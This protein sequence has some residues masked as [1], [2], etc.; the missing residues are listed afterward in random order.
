MADRKAVSRR[1]WRLHWPLLLAATIGIS[2]G[3]IPTMTLGL[4]M[5]PLQN[6]FGWN[7]TTISLGM[8]VFAMLTAPLTPFA[9][10][11]VDRY[12]ARTIAIPGLFLSGLCFA[13]FGLMN[14]MVSVWIGIWVMYSLSSLLCRSVVW[15]PPVSASFVVNRGVAIAILLSGM[16]LASAAS[17]LLTHTLIENLGWRGAYAGVGI[18]WAGFAL[19]L[20]IPFFRIRT[21]PVAA[22]VPNS[23]PARPIMPGGLSGKQALRNR[24]LLRIAAAGLLFST[25]SSA[26]GVHMIPIYTSLGLGRGEAA[27]LALVVGIAG[28]ASKLA[29]GAIADRVNSGF[30]PFAALGLPSVGYALLLI[31]NGSVPLLLAGAIIIGLG[32]GAALHMIM[33]LTTQYGGLRNFG[34]IYG[35]ISALFGLSAGI[36]PV[37]AGAIFDLTGGYSLFLMIGIPMFLVAALLVFGLGPYP[38]FETTGPEP[39]NAGKASASAS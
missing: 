31:G 38:E 26:Y 15:N 3:S 14:G 8:T 22:A 35:S 30:L 29:A 27:G 25:L 37:S 9:G 34:K 10:A 21:E 1:E 13:A 17:P 2:F 36:G 6:E 4:F 5:E 11:L 12:G 32:A 16:S 20:V 18:G 39:E 7:R 33:Y 24:P 19:L 23:P 28:A